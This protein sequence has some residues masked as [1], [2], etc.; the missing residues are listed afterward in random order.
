MRTMALWGYDRAVG[1]A[2]VVG[3]LE[4]MVSRTVFEGLGGRSMQLIHAY[5]PNCPQACS[6][7]AVYAETSTRTAVSRLS[8]ELQHRVG[9]G[10]TAQNSD[11]WPAYAAVMIGDTGKY[12]LRAVVILYQPT[13]SA[14]RL[15]S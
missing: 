13:R 4:I 9:C 7:F 2:L 6:I 12:N 11:V 3:L 5:D 1:A 10:L 15:S 14:Q 8:G